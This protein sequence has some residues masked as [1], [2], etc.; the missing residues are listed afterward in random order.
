MA[1]IKVSLTKTNS[2]K[3]DITRF[4]GLKSVK[5]LS[6]FTPDA[7]KIN[8]GVFAN[9]GD[10]SAIDVNNQ[11]SDMIINNEIAT[12]GG[13]IDISVNSQN[14]SNNIALDSTYTTNDNLL[15]IQISN[16]I[17][18]WDKEYY[19][20]MNYNDASKTLFQIL[21]EVL[22]NYYTQQQLISMM[23]ADIY[24]YLTNIIVQY[25]YL[26]RDTVKNIVNNVCEVAQINIYEGKDGELKFINAR[27]KIDSNNAVIISIPT[28][29]QYSFDNQDLFLRNKYRQSK[30]TYEDFYYENNQ[31]GDIH[32]LT[33]NS[34]ENNRWEIK[35]S[36]IPS[37]YNYQ[38]T[39]IYYQS[40]AQA[41]YGEVTLEFNYKAIDIKNAKIRFSPQ[42]FNFA[43]QTSKE[44]DNTKG[45]IYIDLPAVSSRPA[46]FVPD[47]ND[48]YSVKVYTEYNDEREKIIIHLV[49]WVGSTLPTGGYYLTNAEFA[50]VADEL[51]Y[52]DATYSATH[53][54]YTS[55]QSNYVEL[56]NKNLLLQNGTKYN[57][58]EL[59]E[60]ILDNIMHDY[61]NGIRTMKLTVLCADYYD[62]NGNLVKN[63]SNGDI[64]Q[65]GDIVSV[66]KSNQLNTLYWRVTGR[67][68]RY[69]GCPYLDLELQE[70]KFI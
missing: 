9:S 1:E 49:S 62:T 43:S 21:T 33:Y 44:Q 68:F 22:S 31:V 41:W 15:K 48:R 2:T 3:F 17:S 12:S 55:A 36:E 42:F 34:F 29:K 18:N 6:Q 25:P 40:G 37:K 7:S 5:T 8:Y 63:W 69:S 59:Y 14:Y 28:S 30:I 20:G 35:T 45:A 27:P 16:D 65:P 13:F 19:E 46:S 67:T 56:S 70:V 52:K 4:N 11:I 64:F 51:K 10:I 58:D 26:E 57:G 54:S 38:E 39:T 47:S 32:S 61:Q 50:I 24:Q 23:P 53:S 66:E 60:I